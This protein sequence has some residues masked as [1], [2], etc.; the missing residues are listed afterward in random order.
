MAAAVAHSHKFSV[1]EVS[2]IRKQLLAF[3]D[4]NKRNLPWRNLA[5]SIE[6]ID[7]K[8]YS[9]WVSEIMLQQTQVVTVI[10]YYN[11]WMKKWP[12]LEKLADANLEEVNEMWSGLGYYSR[13]RRLHE[14][15]QKVR[16]AGKGMPRSSKE[17]MKELQGVGRYTAGAI[18]SIA[19]NEVTG[20]VDGNVI[21]VLARL[22]LIGADS[23]SQRVTELMWE[24]ANTIVDTSKP[25]DFN[26]AMMELGATVCTPK[27]P[28]CSTC[29][30]SKVCKA[31]A[32]TVGTDSKTQSSIFSSSLKKNNNNN[33]NTDQLGLTDLEDVAECKYCFTGDTKWRQS[34]GVLNYP[35]KVKMKPAKQEKYF[36]VVIEWNKKFLL[37]Q[38]PNK[39]LLAGLWECPLFLVQEEKK[40]KNETEKETLSNHLFERFDIQGY[41]SVKYLG[42]IVHVFSHVH[43][44][45]VTY[46]IQL[47]AKLEL[48][49]KMTQ[50]AT[51]LTRDEVLQS[52][53]STAVRK[54]FKLYEAG[55][56]TGVKRKRSEATHKQR[57]LDNMLTRVTK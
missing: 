30:L 34:L 2:Y 28:S 7:E 53:I 40:K 5:T 8:A 45:Y 50:C 22:R 57:T 13:G 46:H 1:E 16:K 36:A 12:T 24:L 4:A 52:A 15:A 44:T 29:P 21:R 31:K 32:R 43:H 20:V 41:D 54:I 47:P 42:E 39:G 27:S 49:E 38:R 35:S 56:K 19:Y 23:A 17:L 55:N 9:V 10:D 26:Q 48:R 18:A 6:D 37:V 33:N 25:G 14:A 11:R 3:Y 51:W